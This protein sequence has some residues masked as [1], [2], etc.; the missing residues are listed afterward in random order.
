[1]SDVCIDW[2]L[3]LIPRATQVGLCE[4]ENYETVVIKC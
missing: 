1:M 2:I 4:V 3:S